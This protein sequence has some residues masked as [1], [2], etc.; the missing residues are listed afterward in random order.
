VRT[1][2]RSQVTTSGTSGKV[3]NE[4]LESAGLW[5]PSG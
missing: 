3:S 2:V 5:I 4:Y 1:G